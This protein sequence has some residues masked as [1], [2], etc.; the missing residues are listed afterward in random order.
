MKIITIFA[1]PKNKLYAFEYGEEGDVFRLAFN[2]WN[3]VEYLEEFFEKNKNDL[4]SGFYGNITVEDAVIK[5]L[6][7][8]K[9]LENQFRKIAKNEKNHQLNDVIF[10]PLSENEKLSFQKSKAYG[11]DDK[12][13][14]RI[15][16]IRIDINTFI[17]TGATIKL[18]PKMQDRQHTNQE[19]NKL[20]YAINNLKE[21]GIIDHNDIENIGYFEL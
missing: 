4:Q 20:N 18:T 16:A 21:N 14:L 8:G 19:L 11:T 6:K 13:W 7:E 3:D 5:T 1:H 9:N 12:S 10:K 17:I 2:N 15:Y